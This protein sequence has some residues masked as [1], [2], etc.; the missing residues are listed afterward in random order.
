MNKIIM[1]TV[2]LLMVNGVVLAGEAPPQAMNKGFEK[3]DANS[4][5]MLT[6]EEVTSNSSLAQ[7]F[8]SVDADGSGSIDISEYQFF[9]ALTEAD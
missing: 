7:R 5:G 6:P 3:M 4:D 9:S 2:V 1:F 8:A